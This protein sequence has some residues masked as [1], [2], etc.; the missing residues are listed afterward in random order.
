MTKRK[1]SNEE[2]GAVCQSLTNLFHAGISAGD[3]LDLMA[4]D[5]EDP[6]LAAVLHQMAQRAD[7]GA[8]LEQVFREM[9]CFPAYLCAL[10]EAG[11]RTGKTEHSLQALTDHY[12]AR[13]RMDEHLY[14]ALL[15]PSMLLLVMFAVVA[16]LL[17]WVLPVFDDVYARLGSGL[18]GF[19]GG[20][21]LLGNALRRALPVLCTLLALVV[22]V[23]TLAVAWPRFREWLMT[24]W[25]RM[26][27]D[28]GVFGQINAARFVQVLSLGLSSGL[29]EQ[30]SVQLAQAL[31]Q[32]N[33]R[34]L[35]R[36]EQCLK[37]IQQGAPLAAALRESGLMSKARC[38][39]LEA[40]VRSGCAETVMEQLAGQMLEESEQALE[41]RINGIE[42]TLVLITSVLVGAILLSVMLPLLHIMSGIG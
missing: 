26:R 28:C 22:S 6:R 37:R 27:D 15:Y 20:L 2:L 9:G 38:R 25:R 17:V 11:Q 8:S 1:L 30:E 19:A 40:G 35:N 16:V 7:E 33:P 23:L 31:G 4:R 10:M 29:T 3:A 21:L 42:P 18:T 36:C 5:E 32:E 12:R 14:A 41:M 13:A 34:F 39:L 24:R